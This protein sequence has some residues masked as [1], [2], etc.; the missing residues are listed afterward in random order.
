MNKIKR[1]IR[2]A[3]GLLLGL[4]A[5]ECELD[6]GTLAILTTIVLVEGNVN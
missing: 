3:G 2:R 1:V 5:W 6:D 4:T